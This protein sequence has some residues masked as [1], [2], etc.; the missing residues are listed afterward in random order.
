MMVVVAVKLERFAPSRGRELKYKGD[1]IVP[2]YCKFAP[3]RGRELK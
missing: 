2:I 1:C 3:S